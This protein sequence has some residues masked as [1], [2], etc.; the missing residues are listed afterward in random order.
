MYA[1]IPR[2]LAAKAVAWAWLPLEWV[3]TPFFACSSVMEK[4]AFR[5][6][7]ILKLPVFWNTSILKKSS[8]PHKPLIFFGIGKKTVVSTKQQLASW[9]YDHTY[10]SVSPY[11]RVRE[12]GSDLGVL[13]HDLPRIVHIIQAQLD[14][15]LPKQHLLALSCHMIE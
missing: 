5:A 3:T 4:M 6:P 7:L 9:K 12:D 10:E 15:L 2:N 11:C 1:G 8:R 13:G 14:T